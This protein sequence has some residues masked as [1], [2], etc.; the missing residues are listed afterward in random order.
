MTSVCIRFPQLFDRGCS[1]IECQPDS[2]SEVSGD[3]VPSQ[4]REKF[5]PR[6]GSNNTMS[7]TGDPF[8]RLSSEVIFQGFLS[9]DAAL[10]ARRLS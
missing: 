4:Q 9:V 7:R 10:L 3:A 5:T 6:V 2:L 8:R 1:A